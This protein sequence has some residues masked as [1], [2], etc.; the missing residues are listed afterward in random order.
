MSALLRKFPDDPM[1]SL[2]VR[3]LPSRLG[4]AQRER[5]AIWNAIEEALA[6]ERCLAECL[7][8]RCVAPAELDEWLAPL[9]SVCELTRI[10]ALRE[11]NGDP[12]AWIVEGKLRPADAPT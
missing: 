10:A 5:V 1:V 6:P 12:I 7:K 4:R 11:P 8:R 2:L 9:R 3:S